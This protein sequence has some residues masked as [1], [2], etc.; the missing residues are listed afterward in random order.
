MAGAKPLASLIVS[1]T[2][3]SSFNGDLLSDLMNYTHIIGALQYYTIIRPDITY[4][5]NQLC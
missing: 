4:A 1:G 2:K 3:L 5:V